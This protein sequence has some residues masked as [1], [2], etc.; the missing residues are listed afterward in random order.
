MFIFI[1]AGEKRLQYPV[2]RGSCYIFLGLYIQMKFLSCVFYCPFHAGDKIKSRSNRP[3]WKN[4][5]GTLRRSM[6]AT[7]TKRTHQLMLCPPF[8]LFILTV[9][10]SSPCIYVV[11]KYNQVSTMILISIPLWVVEEESNLVP[12]LTG[13]SFSLL[14]IMIWA[15]PIT[16]SSGVKNWT[17]P[18]FHQKHQPRSGERFG[19][20]LHRW[21]DDCSTMDVD[22]G[23]Y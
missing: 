11:S 4:T 16:H 22:A 13:N 18:T 12:N 20:H 19:I 17:A 15:S 21:S 6:L 9:P 2:D 5:V 14:L 3:S 10:H 8:A 23:I 1:A 7:D